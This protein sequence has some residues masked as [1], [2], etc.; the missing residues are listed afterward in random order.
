MIAQQWGPTWEQPTPKI[1]PINY[2]VLGNK[3]YCIKCGSFIP[4]Y[5]LIA[6]LFFLNPD[7]VIYSNCIIL[8]WEKIFTFHRVMEIHIFLGQL[9]ILNFEDSH[10]LTLG[11]QTGRLGAG[12]ML[13]LDLKLF[14]KSGLFFNLIFWFPM[15]EMKSSEPHNHKLDHIY[16]VMRWKIFC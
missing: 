5:Y 7:R 12:I 11:A 14:C 15:V 16:T 8:S 9:E 13:D 3:F 1:K 10:V 4:V 6:D 2:R